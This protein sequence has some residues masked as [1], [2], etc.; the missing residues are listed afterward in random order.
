[1][2]NPRALC[3]NAHNIGGGGHPPA[4]AVPGTILFEASPAGAW[5]G[6]QQRFWAESQ[7]PPSH[8]VSVLFGALEEA[9]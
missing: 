2:R 7:P 8:L 6:Q 1:M 5:E 4:L 3:Y 9:T